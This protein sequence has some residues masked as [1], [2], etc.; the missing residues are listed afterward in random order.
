MM[1]NELD[2]LLTAEG[3]KTKIVFGISNNKGYVP[4]KERLLNPERFI[5]MFAP[6]SRSFAEPF[7]EE[8]R[9][10][11]APDY[12]INHF[13]M[14]RSVDELL[15]FLYEWEQIYDGDCVDFDYH[16]MWTHFLDAGGEEISDIIYHDLK[17][18]DKLGMNGFISCQL[19]RNTFPTS[20][21]MTVM[22]KTLWNKNADF[23]E[24]RDTLYRN[25]FGEEHL[26]ILKEYFQILT[27]GFNIGTLRSQN[28]ATKEDIK[29]NLQ[30]A[31]DAMDKIAPL[32]AE[33]KNGSG[34]LARSWKLLDLHREIYSDF[35]K[36]LLARLVGCNDE[37]D[38]IL[39][40]VIDYLWH[41]ED[42]LD[43]ATDTYFFQECLESRVNLKKPAEFMDSL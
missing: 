26:P 42:E 1:L 3:L 9:V 8:F 27:N 13:S 40:S 22:G 20:L 5:L 29:Q 36:S 18:L 38:R 2:A 30:R 34:C 24:M 7:P 10:K 25:M 35:G 17:R 39:Q 37:A 19:Q 16:L 41:H 43:G 33:Q 31:I 11:K 32:I 28:G 4:L 12:E 23:A 6:I 15:A 21:A 14:P